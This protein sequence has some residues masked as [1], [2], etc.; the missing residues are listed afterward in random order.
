VGLVLILNLCFGLAA[1][2]IRNISLTLAIILLLQCVVILIL[3]TILERAGNLHERRK[4]S[5]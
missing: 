3:V 2:I 5:S 4:I 1:L